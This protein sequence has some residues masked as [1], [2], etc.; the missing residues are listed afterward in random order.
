M[1]PSSGIGSHKLDVEAVATFVE[2]GHAVF[3]VLN[4]KTGGRFTYKV[5]A[6]KGENTAVRYF[7]SVLN[8]SDNTSD[9]IY[10]GCVYKDGA[11]RRGVKS[12]IGPDAPS[13]KGFAWIWERREKMESYSHVEVLHMGTCGKC[14]RALTVPESVKSGLGPVCAGKGGG[15]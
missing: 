3:T 12:T 2:G 6:P 8:G 9:Y 14:G 5:S 13:M 7:V 10:L 1:L 4:T 11:F 15:E